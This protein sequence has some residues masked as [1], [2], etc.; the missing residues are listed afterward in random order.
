MTGLISGLDTESMVKEIV[1]ASSTKVEDAKKAKQKA[2]WKKEAWASLN[3]KILNFYKTSLSAF[4]TNGS[5]KAKSA[6]ANDTTKVSV[7]AGLNANAGTHVVSVKQLASSA[8]LTGSNIKKSN[9][10]YTAHPEAGLTTDFADM[11]DADGNSLGLQGQTIS[12]SADGAGTK[13][14]VLGGSG[15]NGVKNLEELNAKLA[16]DENFKGLQVSLKDGKINFTNTSATTDDQGNQTGTKYVVDAGA[17]GVQGVV[18][19]DKDAATGNVVSADFTPKYETQFTSKDIT[20]STKLKDLGIAV[21]TS[22]SIKGNDFVVDDSTSL[23]DLAAGFSKMGISANFDA[24]QGRFYLNASATGSENDFNVTSSDAG[25][26]ELLGLGST[27]TKIDATDAI[28]DYNGVEYIGSSNTF[29]I[30]GLDI[31]AKAVTGEYDATTGVFKNDTPINIAVDTDTDGMYKTIKDFV[32]SYNELI[33]EMNKLY[34]EE[35]TDYDPLTDDERAQLSDNQI[36]KW[37]EKAKQGLLRRDSTL[38]SLTSQMRSILNSGVTVTNADGTTTRYSLASLGIVTGSDYTEKGK[39]HIMGDEDDPEFSAQENVLKKKL[40]EQPE[41][42]SKVLAGTSENQ[43]LGLQVYN[44]LTKAMKYHE[45]VSSSQ[46]VYNNLSM[47]EEIDDW[48]DKIDELNEKLQKMEDKYYKQFSAMEAA[49]AK[50]QQQQSALA[51]ML[52]MGS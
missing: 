6:T 27:A 30:N 8:Y 25:A 18:D 9:Q 37:E 44:Y 16:E 52:G 29:N 19:Y 38:N 41:I 14:F 31:T 7:K 49:M 23:D 50:M 21:G 46:T 40:Q 24:G 28:I 36:E 51:S 42:F 11:T 17:F 39:L 33:D 26:L 32:K 15:D 47:D 43:G 12:I 34:D 48:D 1:K 10:N 45:G 3:T 5:Y 13:E 4:K 20:G 35:K 2:E 22:F